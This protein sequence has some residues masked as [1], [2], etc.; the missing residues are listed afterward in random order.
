MLIT[1]TNTH[2]SQTMQSNEIPWPLSING[3]TFR[4]QSIKLKKKNK[5]EKKRMFDIATKRLKG[6]EKV[7]WLTFY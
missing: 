4:T 6:I 2:D 3:D 1:H 5:S 7:C